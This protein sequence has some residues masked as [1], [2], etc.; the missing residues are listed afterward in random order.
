MATN[1]ILPATQAALKVERPGKVTIAESEPLP[2]LGP[3][4]VLVHNVCIG[5]NPF[6]CNSVDISPSV[7]ATVGGDFAGKIAALGEEV[8]A[9]RFQIGD[10]VFGCVFGNNPDHQQNGAF[11]K[12]VVVPADFVLRIRPNISFQQAATLGIGLATIGL[13]LFKGL[14]LPMSFE[15]NKT[16][17][18]K[19]DIVLLYGGGTATGSLAIQVIRR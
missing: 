6:D 5:L 7:G 11:A 8:P 18:K 2:A 17:G 3:H 4:D 12:Y 13:A 9:D 19:P 14:G 16:T 1:I 15:D 10:R